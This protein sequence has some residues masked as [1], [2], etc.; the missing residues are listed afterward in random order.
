MIELMHPD[1]RPIAG[2]ARVLRE[3]FE[4]PDASERVSR[5]ARNR[6]PPGNILLSKMNVRNKF[7]TY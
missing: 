6:I 1:F 7:F 4:T 2:T 3:F 5:A